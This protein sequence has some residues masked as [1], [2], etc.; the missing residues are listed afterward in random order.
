MFRLAARS[1]DDELRVRPWHH[2][3]V[4]D[5]ALDVT[6][7][8]A[9]RPRVTGRVVL[10]SMDVAIP[11]RLSGAGQ[12]LAGAVHLK[13]TPEAL[14][15]LNMEKA[16]AARVARGPAFNADIDLAVSA[17]SKIFVRGRGLDAELGGDLKLTGT[18]DKPIAIGAFEM[19]R[20]RLDLAS[21]RLEF[22]RGRID[23]QGDLMPNLDFV[24]QSLAA[25]VT[26]QVSVSGPASKP[27]FTF[28]STPALPQDEVISRL[29]F[30]RASG[31]LS[32]I[33]AL[34]LA[35]TVAELS[36]QGGPG[37]FDRLRRSL[38]VDSVDVNVGPDGKPT[39]GASKY[40]TR[41]VNVGV[42]TGTRPEDSAVTIGVD[43][44]RRVKVQGDM[45]ADGKASVGVGAEWEY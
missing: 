39:V 8:L 6:G 32:P 4:A 28:S 20:G 41:N 42:R 23:F 27:V 19:R 24:A 1:H 37:V 35:A 12:P 31:G 21:Q 13:P 9:R 17:P 33:Q 45:G 18:L 30:S 36:G 15:L 14:V 11:D 2:Q 29:L 3:R 22:S 26:A 40:I 5:L 10:Q 25:D 34:Q 16:R 43:V 7:P 38:G 44:S